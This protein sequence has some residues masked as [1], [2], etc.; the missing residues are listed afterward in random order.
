MGISIVI[1]NF[2]GKEMLKENLPVLVDEMTASGLEYEI[3]LV[4]DASTD[5]SADWIKANFPQI[6]LIQQN[7]NKGFS[8]TINAGVKVSQF[9]LLLLLNSDIKVKKNFLKPLL[10]FLA[11]KKVFAVGNKAVAEDGKDLTKPYLMAFKFGFLREAFTGEQITSYAFGASG[12]HGLFDKNKFI[13][14]GLLDEVFTP[15][16]WEDADIGYRAWKRGY[17]L[18]YEPSSAVYH[19]NMAT[20]GKINK[21]FRNFIFHRNYFIFLWKNLTDIEFLIVH[22][23][24]LPF[25]LFLNSLHSPIIFLSFLA[26][27]MKL[28][29]IWKARRYEKQFIKRTDKEV[30]NLW[31]QKLNWP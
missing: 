20:I 13:E 6:H 14:L 10:P 26:A 9:E 22:F 29:H 1:P 11:N 27:L 7:Q 16:Y 30:L 12:G 8:V 23:V 2:N 15:F 21:K 18:Y 17:F 28:K 19:K 4:D 25:Y 3:I 24:F 5:G 31:K